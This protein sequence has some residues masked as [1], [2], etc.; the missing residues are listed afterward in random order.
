MRDADDDFEHVIHV[1]LLWLG[2]APKKASTVVSESTVQTE[3]DVVAPQVV[4]LTND[5]DPRIEISALAAMSPSKTTAT[6]D[7]WRE[8]DNRGQ[9]SKHSRPS[10]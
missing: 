2:V 6:E 8:S 3:S 1:K 5:E 4:E 10:L 7:Q 9:C